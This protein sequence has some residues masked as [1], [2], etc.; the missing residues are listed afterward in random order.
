M[1]STCV[2]NDCRVSRN[3][4]VSASRDRPSS[5]SYFSQRL[6]LHYLDWGNADSPPLLLIHGIH[7]HCRSWDWLVEHLKSDF[8]VIAP[9][10]RG[11]GDSEWSTGSQ[12]M[13]LEYVYDIAQLIQQQHLSPLT[14]LSHS[15]GGT[16]AS[17]YCGLYPETIKRLIIIEGVGL[18]PSPTFAGPAGRIRAWIETGRNLAGRHVRRYPSIEDAYHRMHEMNPHL[19]TDQAKH[20]SLHA[21]NQNEDGTYSWKFDNYTR[22]RSPYDMPNDHLIALWQEISAPVLIINSV[23]GYPHRI[24]QDGTDQYFSDLKMVRVPGSG[25]WVHHDQLAEVVAATREFLGIESTASLPS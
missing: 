21:S 2:S 12:Y 25:H 14:I 8:H 10:L 13:L 17:I 9:D 6:R 23:H 24:G 16:I 20:L 11:H 22:N 15:L 19:S 18:Y 1:L 5:H 7:D 4:I 3:A